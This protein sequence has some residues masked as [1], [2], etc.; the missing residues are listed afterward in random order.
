ME[1]KEIL[2]KIALPARS[3][4]KGFK[5]TDKLVAIKDLLK[6]ENSPYQL[7]C[8]SPQVWI[9]GKRNPKKNDST[10]LI[11]THAD[12]VKE[13]TKPFSE[14]IEDEKYFKG[15]YDNL[16]TNA[17]C[18][19]L[20]LNEALP[21]NVYFAFTADEETGRC[22]GARYA[23]SYIKYTT[24]VTPTIFA[25]DVTE[26]GYDNDRLFTIE[27]LHA[28][29]EE[30]RREMLG[31]FMETEGEEQSFEVVR[32]KKKDDNSFLPES[33]QAEDTTEYDESVFY[34]KQDCNSCSICLPGDGSMHS[35]SGFFVKESVMK[36]YGLSLLS[37]ILSF[38]E[39]D[40]TRIEE[41]KN[42]KDILVREAK[43]TSF[44]KFYSSYSS[45][46]TYSSFHS[47]GYYGG[48]LGSY[49]KRRM[50]EV[51]NDDFPG[52]MSL[53]DFDDSFED[54]YYDSDYEEKDGFLLNDPMLVASCVDDFYEFAQAYN[55]DEF[56]MFYSDVIYTYGFKYEGALEEYLL[57]IFEEVHEEYEEEYE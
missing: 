29:T 36:G 44:H 26:E 16:G 24:N 40:R 17:V 11:S 38:T 21:D 15:T 7:V 8:E 1:I 14:Y 35:N 47:N 20:M 50:R 13:I 5:E 18:L 46:G 39:K 42:Q 54:Y 28:K 31:L 55:I 48:G 52:Q 43:E 25:L 56:D 2:E 22:N 27:G 57:G 41:I 4:K 9:F 33:Y 49:W 32:L 34:A 10:L 3:N 51:E 37:C 19:N 23:L 12:I 53:V 45:L 6:E 30:K